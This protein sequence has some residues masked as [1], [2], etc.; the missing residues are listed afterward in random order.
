[1]ENT[2][3]EA[4]FQDQINALSQEGIGL[5]KRVSLLS[6][7]RVSLFL[8]TLI[9]IFAFANERSFQLMIWTVV[10]FVPLFGIIV[11]AHNKAKFSALQNNFLIEI[12][13][14][15][16]KRLNGDLSSLDDGAAFEKDGHNYSM[17][18]DIFGSNSLFQL[19]VRSKLGGTIHLLKGWM[20][21]AG[22]EQEISDRQEA[23]NELVKETRW[24]QHLT[25][26]GYH[27]DQS[28]QKYHN[29]ISSLVVWLED[30][31]GKVDHV[32]W[33][34]MNFL[35]P[36]VSMVIFGGMVLFDWSSQWLLI[37]VVINLI[38]LSII[39]KPLLLLT[40][41]FGGIA[42]FLK[43]Y[44]QVIIEI[45]SR[46][47]KSHFL[48]SLKSQLMTEGKSASGAIRYLRRT[49]MFLLN[50][51]SMF[52]QPL[53]ILFLLDVIWLRMA[54]KWK[55]A[56]AKDVEGWF[57]SVH[58]IDALSDLAS[59][60]Y[61]N[62]DFTVPVLSDQSHQ[63]ITK[64][65]GHPMIKSSQRVYNDFELN[66][67]GC[68]GLVTGSNMSGKSTFQRTVGIN[69]VLAQM[70]APVCASRFEFSRVRVFT[71]M[72][73]KDNLEENV[74]SFYAELKR[75]KELLDSINE[76][77]PTFYMLD[78]ILKGT[79]SD[80]RHKGAIS[81]IDQLTKKSCR[82]LV[83]THDIELSNLSKDEPKILNFSFNSTIENDEIIF[84]YKIS[85]EPCK[86]FNASKLME[87]MGIIVS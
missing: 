86:S 47:F 39:F 5:K 40:K 30:N 6:W 37:P 54:I 76:E 44:E 42:D 20:L 59:L 49:L 36:T 31:L 83:S 87:K 7:V 81:L 2:S 15:E 26:F 84:D 70:G 18:L 24:R 57:E 79:N 67:E 25:A 11:T 62:P 75:L 3:R 64:E 16:L 8:L 19:I 51:A 21:K 12:N 22:S 71:S 68:L 61:A 73:T 1:M 63:L 65:M 72:R 35:M 13:E 29:V 69:L 55:N 27:G 45:E 60:A 38:L 43:G 52:Y 66:K 53:N 50:R 33:R 28:S 9:A 32:F 58:H 34:I 74:S 41:E 46:E 56:H 80:D 4:F 85:N 14:N 82:G 77:L 10:G 78:E 23:V 48:S 17:D